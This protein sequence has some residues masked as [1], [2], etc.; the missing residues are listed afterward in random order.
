MSSNGTASQAPGRQ[1]SAGA[2]CND[3]ITLLCP[4]QILGFK[5]GAL[6][7]DYDGELTARHAVPLLCFQCLSQAQ[8]TE[9]Q[10]NLVNLELRLHLRVPKK[11]KGIDYMYII[12][13]MVVTNQL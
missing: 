1:L 12:R 5:C 8:N 13:Q 2:S 11:I 3:V 6:V 7:Q 9:R 4:I 10:F